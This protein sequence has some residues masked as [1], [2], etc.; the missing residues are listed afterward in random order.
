MSNIKFG[1][2]DKN[3]YCEK[4]ADSLRIVVQVSP[5]PKKSITVS[6]DDAAFERG[7]VW[8]RK[9]RD[10]LRDVKKGKSPGA[11][12][13]V[14]EAS[15]P[16]AFLPGDIS[17]CDILDN[18]RQHRPSLVG[19][20]QRSRTETIQVRPIYVRLL[21]QTSAAYPYTLPCPVVIESRTAAFGCINN[22]SSGRVII[23]K[24]LC[25]MTIPSA[26]R[27]YPNFRT[28][29]FSVLPLFNGSAEP[30]VSCSRQCTHWTSCP[31]WQNQLCS[32]LCLSGFG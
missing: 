8:A 20:C 18:Y 24:L 32:H 7:L 15:L 1:A 4:R 19:A 3:I 21:F 5:H 10:A 30:W 25:A 28:L 27:C 12:R 29:D 6:N 9:E 13:L 14:P 11:A 17:I 2:V 22:N 31:A 16:V 23:E 26:Y